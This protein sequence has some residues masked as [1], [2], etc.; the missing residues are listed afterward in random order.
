MV[1]SIGQPR[2]DDEHDTFAKAIGLKLRSPMKRSSGSKSRVP[3]AAILQ[4]SLRP[5]PVGSP[6]GGECVGQQLRRPLSAPTLASSA[7]L[8][9]S[10][11]ELASSSQPPLRQQ[12][13][14][15][16]ASASSKGG[17]TV[18]GPLTAHSAWGAAGAAAAKRPSGV[19]TQRVIALHAQWRR[20]SYAGT[21]KMSGFAHVLR[22]HYPTASRQALESMMAEVAP[23]IEANDRRHWVARTRAMRASDLRNA[24]GALFHSNSASAATDDPSALPV[25]IDDFLSAVRGALATA[26]QPSC[27]RS[28]PRGSGSRAASAVTSAV[29]SASSSSSAFSLEL[30]SLQA[31]LAS[32][33]DDAVQDGG[34]HGG[35]G[36]GTIGLSE[37]LE[38]CA[39]H[40]SVVA[41]FDDIVDI[42]L[43]AAKDRERARL[44]AVYRHPVSPAKSDGRGGC[45]VK[46]PSSG[47]RFRPTLHD[48]R[49][50]HEVESR[51]PRH[52]T[53]SRW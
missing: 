47:V 49:P 25:H 17:F 3:L 4:T 12:Q 36:G 31:S 8:L 26:Q 38:R 45:V 18:P 2:A 6:T 35:G 37:L 27:L 5:T 43:N 20:S 21:H 1:R 50:V 19:T 16:V 24:F 10:G 40:P 44:S 39:T 11:A 53:S 22:A 23:A 41:A 30:E 52:A 28:L 14:K 48:L 32:A 29:S 34:G 9:C 51:L 33:A 13:A 46:S 15:L 7:K 42:G